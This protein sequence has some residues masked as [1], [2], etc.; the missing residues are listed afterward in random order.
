M[1]EIW[2]H[3]GSGERYL[4]IVRAGLPTVAAG[5]LP[6]GSDPRVVLESRGNKQHNA[7]ALLSMRRAPA[8]YAREYTTDKHGRA[9]AVAD[10]TPS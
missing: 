7:W 6:P 2:R 10:G 8:E 1:F 4:V 5:P 9:V 3:L